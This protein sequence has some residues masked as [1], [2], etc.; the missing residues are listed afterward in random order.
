MYIWSTERNNS[1]FLLL[2]ARDSV[3]M[4]QKTWGLSQLM[5]SSGNVHTDEKTS[6]DNG[7]V[8]D[9]RENRIKSMASKDGISTMTR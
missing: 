6:I 2:E 5:G 3:K 8:I 7:T 9:F 1:T 4:S